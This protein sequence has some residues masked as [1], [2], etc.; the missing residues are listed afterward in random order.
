M[1]PGS[2]VTEDDLFDLVK[3][4]EHFNK[5]PEVR[6]MKQLERLNVRAFK[7]DVVKLLNNR[8]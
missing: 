2:F 3:R 1:M 5:F 7:N 6:D 4:H 8:D